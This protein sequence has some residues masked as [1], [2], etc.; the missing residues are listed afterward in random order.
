MAKQ[1]YSELAE[2]CRNADMVVFDAAYSPEDYPDKKGYG[3]STIEDGFKLAKLSKCKR[4]MF[5]HFSFEY[6]DDDLTILEARVDVQG[7]QFLFAR[8]GLELE[9]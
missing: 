6:S 3:H 7:R 4:M 8:D 9:L 2:F 1:E 5:S